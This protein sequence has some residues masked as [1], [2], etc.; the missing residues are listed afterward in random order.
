LNEKGFRL[1]EYSPEKAGVG[2]STP[3]LATIIPKDLDLFTVCLQPKVQPK[4]SHCTV[5]VSR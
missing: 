5:S 1:K 3:S 2:G 4:I